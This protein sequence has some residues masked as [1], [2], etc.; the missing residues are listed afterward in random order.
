M[1]SFKVHLS[2]MDHILGLLEKVDALVLYINIQSET[3]T[4]TAA[5]RWSFNTGGH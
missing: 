4:L 1:S 5:H 2:N 3:Y